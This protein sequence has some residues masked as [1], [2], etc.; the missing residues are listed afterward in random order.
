MKF[1]NLCLVA[2]LALVGCSQSTASTDKVLNPG[3]S[4]EAP[5]PNT[6]TQASVP[7]FSKVT[8]RVCGV[9]GAKEPGNCLTYEV[10]SYHWGEPETITFAKRFFINDYVYIPVIRSQGCV[11]IHEHP[12]EEA[13]YSEKANFLPADSE[14]QMSIEFV[15]VEPIPEPQLDAQLYLIRATNKN[16]AGGKFCEVFEEEDLL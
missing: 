5:Q 4:S 10:S 2:L 14:E 12:V 9:K 6:Q 8:W 13:Y 11:L 1:F 3:Q 16:Y 15:S 7:Q